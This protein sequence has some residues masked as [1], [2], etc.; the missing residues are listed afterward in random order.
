MKETK[1]TQKSKI[2]NMLDEIDELANLDLN[3]DNNELNSQQDLDKNIKNLEILN[4]ALIQEL[5]H[6][7]EPENKESLETHLQEEISPELRVCVACNEPIGQKSCCKISQGFYHVEHFV[8]SECN[9]SLINKPFYDKIG[10]LYCAKDYI[11]K[12]AH[13]CEVC[14]EPVLNVILINFNVLF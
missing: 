13:L 14:K 8:C 2:N 6:A 12:F 1:N 10:K 5:D 4:K 9:E 3:I 11:S 7:D